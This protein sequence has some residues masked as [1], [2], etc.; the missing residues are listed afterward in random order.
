MNDD[1]E[2]WSA[3]ER[4]KIHNYEPNKSWT[5][6]DR[7]QLPSGRSLVPL[8]TSERGTASLKRVCVSRDAPRCTA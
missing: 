8:S 1:A 3:A 5:Y 4:P 7:G 6:L 2:G